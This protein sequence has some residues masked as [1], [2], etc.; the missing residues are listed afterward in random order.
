MVSAVGQRFLVPIASSLA[1]SYLEIRK[2]GLYPDNI[3]FACIYQYVEHFLEEGNAAHKALFLNIVGR[4]RVDNQVIAA[5]YRLFHADVDSKLLSSAEFQAGLMEVARILIERKNLQTG[6][7]YQIIE[8]LRGSAEL[9]HCRGEVMFLVPG[10]FEMRRKLS[11]GVSGPEIL[12]IGAGSQLFLLYD[13]L[14]KDSFFL[15]ACHCLSLRYHI[16]A[17]FQHKIGSLANT[18]DQ[19]A[20]L[21]VKCSTNEHPL[22]KADIGRLLMGNSCDFTLQT[23]KQQCDHVNEAWGVQCMMCENPIC[24]ICLIAQA[25]TAKG[26]FCVKCKMPYDLQVPS[27][28]SRQ[29]YDWTKR[30]FEIAMRKW[31]LEF[32]EQRQALELR[33]TLLSR[34]SSLPTQSVSLPSHRLDPHLPARPN[35]SQTQRMPGPPFASKACK[36][37]AL[38]VTYSICS[39]GCYCIAC[40]VSNIYSS[41]DL[42]KQCIDCKESALPFLDGVID[43]VMCKKGFTY[44]EM[45]FACLICHYRI[46][47]S[48]FYRIKGLISNCSTSRKPHILNTA[49]KLKS[50][51]QKL[52]RAD[53]LPSSSYLL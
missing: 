17:D 34:T 53:Y 52:T 20:T 8:T 35:P 43:C 7:D 40:A 10:E 9:L 4:F 45:A 26:P 27:A 23:D 22:S 50:V 6:T 31:H 48:C 44:W 28:L 19:L 41:I 3:L 1:S 42:L 2:V 29:N 16:F 51:E 25:L 36:R 5:F 38:P 33:L 12:T 21:S 39:L 32:N 24:G 46:C 18:I 15:P 37:C 47:T 13:Y 11:F 14:A 49:A 30:F